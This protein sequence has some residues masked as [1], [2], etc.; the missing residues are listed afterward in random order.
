MIVHR[1]HCIFSH[2]SLS[3][4]TITEEIRD[5]LAASFA[6]YGCDQIV[7]FPR[8]NGDCRCVCHSRTSQR[9]PFNVCPRESSIPYAARGSPAGP[10]YPPLIHHHHR[11][12]AQLV[13][14]KAPSPSWLS[15]GLAGRNVRTSKHL[16]LLSPAPAASLSPGVGPPGWPRPGWPERS[17]PR[18]GPQRRWRPGGGP[19]GPA[20]GRWRAD[21]G[22]RRREPQRGQHAPH[23]VGPGH[24]AQ[25]RRRQGSRSA[26]WLRCS[27]SAGRSG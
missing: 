3:A 12:R 10:A 27:A 23:G 15:P 4:S 1:A 20:G 11:W 17:A 18:A 6:L 9:I 14:L 13:G 5:Y 7:A 19:R 22:R 25:H 2:L 21:R 16:S 8:L 24:G 26:R